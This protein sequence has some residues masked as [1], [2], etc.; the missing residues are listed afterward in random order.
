MFIILHIYNKYF[1]Y[2]VVNTTTNANTNTN[3]NNNTDNIKILNDYIKSNNVDNL[4]SLNNLK[5]SFPKDNEECLNSLNHQ[6]PN[7]NIINKYLENSSRNIDNIDNTDNINILMNQNNLKINYPENNKECLKQYIDNTNILNNY[8]EL[9]SHKFDSELNYIEN[10]KPNMIQATKYIW[11]Y[12]EN[13]NRKTFPTYIKLCMDTMKKHLSSKYNLIFLNEQIIKLYLPDLRDDFNNLKIAQKVDYYRIAL[14]YKYGGIWIDAD[15][16][17]MKDFD[18]IFQKLDEGYDY[19]GFG[20]TG[21]TCSFGY[22]RPSNWVMAS[23]PNSILMKLCLDKLN[24]KLDNRNKNETQNDTT[25]HDYGK[26]ILWNSLDELKH[27]GY[28]YYHFSSEFDGARDINKNWIH[29]DN[30]FSTNKTLF[31][32]ESKLLFV[33]LYNSEISSNPKYKWIFD[34]DESKLLYGNEWICYLFRKS[35]NIQ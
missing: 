21:M 19:V 9:N 29:V 34:T 22:F 6:L 15:I 5:I 27:N 11:V 35:L 23:K 33:V 17:V 28:K 13:I 7:I 31:L 4:M 18:L 3:T 24:Y 8:L 12:W 2:T 32:N 30:F 14:L 1:D 26:I 10:F 16:I 25:Y 20:C